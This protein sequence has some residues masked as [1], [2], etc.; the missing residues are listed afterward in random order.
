[1]DHTEKASLGLGGDY[2]TTVTLGKGP[3]P[4]GFLPAHL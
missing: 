2:L 1:M 3:L 4:S